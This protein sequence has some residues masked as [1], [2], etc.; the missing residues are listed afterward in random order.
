MRVELAFGLL[1]TKWQI[2]C[3]AL[4]LPLAESPM[5]FQ[6]CCLLHNFCINERLQLDNEAHIER[7]YG[8]GEMQLGY[9]P[10]DISSAPLS[11]SVLHTR[12]VQ[13][14]QN[15]SWSCP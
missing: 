8:A 14:T 3:T 15:K 4:E 13:R 10:S 1:K 6:V 9:I 7:M 12:I 5:I 2:L 11:G